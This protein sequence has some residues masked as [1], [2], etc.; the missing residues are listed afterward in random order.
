MWRVPA[1]TETPMARP[2]AS[3]RRIVQGVSVYTLARALAGAV[4]LAAV[5]IIVHAV[6]AAT[7]GTLTAL[8]TLVLVLLACCDLGLGTAALR[9]TPECRSEAERRVLFGTLFA[10]RAASG[11]V[12]SVAVAIFR[13]PIAVLVTGEAGN[14]RALVLLLPA[15]PIAATF[16]AVM[17][18]LR[19]RRAFNKVSLGVFVAQC[20]V[21]AFTVLLTT[22]G[23]W[24]LD[25]LAIAQGV[26]YALALAAGIVLAGPGAFGRPKLPALA[27]MA[28]FGWPLGSLYVIGT[29]RGIDRL[30]VR[31]AVS[32]EAVGAYELAARL[33][34]PIGLANLAL[35]TVLE[36]LVYGSASSPR[37]SLVLDRYVRAYATVFGAVAM[38]LG[39]FSPEVVNVLAPAPYRA[40]ALALPGL[41]FG[42]A[43]DGLVR[44]AGIGADLAKSTRVW[45]VT[46]TVSLVLGI[47]LAVALVP[48]MG[49][50]GAAIAWTCASAAALLVAYRAG[51]AVSGIV[52]P[53]ER[54]VLVLGSGAVLTTLSVVQ[55][56]TVLARLALLLGFIVIA[57]VVLRPSFRD[58]SEVVPD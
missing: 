38:T 14:A 34:G 28:R 46:S 57:S 2:R 18:E 43:C 16:E 55:G 20:A 4:R 11:L 33:V 49:V 19:S 1:A 22:W 44:P 10:Q 52:L 7:Y 21:Q 24:G 9:L 29:L 15:L 30:V 39:S 25:G 45:A 17:D 47:G 12:V 23:R 40:A 36:P 53:V 50:A 3:F 13:V 35:V 56:F 8:W 32:L 54:A 51:R 6:S 41:A 58:L 26:G 37:T 42:A 31:E 5:P 27:R 48:R